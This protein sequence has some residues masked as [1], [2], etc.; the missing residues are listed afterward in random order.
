MSLY[1]KIRAAV[2]RRRK[3]PAPPTDEPMTCRSPQSLTEAELL[4]IEQLEVNLIDRMAWEN[5]RDRQKVEGLTDFET[6]EL[7]GYYPKCS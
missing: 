1:D 7:T 3:K 5:A 6:I 2:S 4:M